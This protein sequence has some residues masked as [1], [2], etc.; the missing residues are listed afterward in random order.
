MRR[1]SRYCIVLLLISPALW[2]AT[3][4][5]S[6]RGLLIVQQ[7]AGNGSAPCVSCHGLDGAGNA[8]LVAPRLAGLDAAYLRKQLQ[9]YQ[10]GQ[11]QSALM[12][13]T[14]AKLTE[15]QIADVAAY[16][17]SQPVAAIPPP[18]VSPE[19]LALGERL[20]MRGNWDSYIVPCTTC[21][22]PGNRGVGGDFPLLAGQYANYLQQQLQEWK[23]GNRH[24]DPNQLMLAIAG[25]LSD[26][27]IAAVALYL[28][29][30]SPKE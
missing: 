6:Q 21:H 19:Q 30:L 8:A 13:P 9:D 22:G 16:Y 26:A 10:S 3:P 25:R 24:N 18:A 28:A 4:A 11:R 15:Q 29:R 27:Q 17:S 23:N 7:G 1:I 12:L 14:V 20:A 2:A 5:D